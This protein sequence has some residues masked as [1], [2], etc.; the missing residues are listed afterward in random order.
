MCSNSPLFALRTASWIPTISQHEARPLCACEQ[1]ACTCSPNLAWRLYTLARWL[2]SPGFL[3]NSQARLQMQGLLINRALQ[4]PNILCIDPNW[5]RNGLTPREAHVGS[6]QRDNWC[7][8]SVCSNK[9]RVCLAIAFEND[10]VYW[11]LIDGIPRAGI[12][13]FLG[14]VV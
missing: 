13:K 8:G 4:I 3:L 6:T 1:L 11:L 12:A 2:T 7:K 10:S 5:Q 14:T 9:R